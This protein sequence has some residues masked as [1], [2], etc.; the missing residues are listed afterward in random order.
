MKISKIQINGFGNLLN[1]NVEFS[2]GINLIRGENESGK[3]TLVY[4]IKS[5][6]YGIDK[7]KSGNIFS[8]VERYKPWKSTEFSGKMDYV[9]DGKKYSTYRDFNRNNSKVFDE[10]G[11]DITSEFNKGKNRGAEIGMTH[12]NIDEETFLNSAFVSQGSVAVGDEERKSII[13][14]LTNI[15]QSGEE[16]ISYDKA[17]DRIHKILLEEVGTDR[18]HNKPINNVRKEIEAFEK[19]RNNLLYTRDRKED[20]TERKKILAKRIEEVE[21]D[22]KNAQKVYEVKDRYARML[23]EREKEYEISLRLLEKEKEER[24]K[25]REISRKN[26]VVAVLILALVSFAIL[27]F[28][29]L[30]IWTLIPILSSI[31]LSTIISKTLSG[32]IKQNLPQ[33]IDVIRENLKRKEQ[34]ELETFKKEDIKESLINRRLQDL[35]TLI[36]GMEKN[37]N[38][39]ILEEHKLKIENDGISEHLDRLNDVEEQLYDLYEKRNNLEKLQFSLKIASEKL[40]EAYEELKKEIVPDIEET[41]KTNTSIVTNGKYKNVIYND[42]QGLM[43]ENSVGEIVTIDKLSMGT[44]DQIY[45]G[46]RFAIAEKIGNVPMFLDEAFAYYDNERLENI[47]NTIKEKADTNQVFIMTCSDRERIALDKLRINYNDISL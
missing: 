26:S 30:Y 39:L 43:I 14:K 18:T 9:I 12:L 22:Y 46:F 47:L 23:S 24:V 2:D 38:D 27:V 32:E 4:F 6:L 45:L 16:S 25:K 10:E 31:I 29:R 34:K 40:E 1:K 36:S 37:K 20:I 15:I 44:I 3:S 42:S 5:M 11:N 7:N 21:E 33:D 19:T 35:K 8:E 41:I 17:Q 28:Y 13:Q